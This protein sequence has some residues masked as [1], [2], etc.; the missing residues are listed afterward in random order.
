MI[1]WNVNPEIFSIGPV[2]LRYYG[3]LFLTGFVIGYHLIKKYFLRA[4]QSIEAVDS[5]FIYMIIG[6][7]VGARAGHV[8]FYDF[9]EFMRDPIMLFQIWKGGLASHG[10]VI[11]ILTSVW[12]YCRKWKMPFLWVMDHVAT[13]TALSAVFIRLGNLMNSEIIGKP[14]DVPWS[15]VFLHVDS[16]PRHPTQIYEALFYLFTFVVLF[17]Y[18]NNKYKNNQGFILGLFFVLIFGWRI[19]VEQFKEVQV[20]FEQG[21]ALNMGQLLSIPVI[22]LGIWLMARAKPQEPWWD[23]APT[24]KKKR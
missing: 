5:L 9:Q 12:L 3:I 17:W 10:A 16:I 6:T 24:K 2:T 22:A 14:A 20:A 18:L 23:E 21:M 4:R 19:F 15:F 8:F 11:G 1:Q 7:T 13:F